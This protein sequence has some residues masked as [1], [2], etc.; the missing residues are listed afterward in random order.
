MAGLLELKEVGFTYL[1]GTPVA[2]EVLQGVNLALAEGEILCLLGRTGSGKTTLLQIMAGFLSPTRGFVLLNGED[3]NEE[4]RRRRGTGEVAMLMQASHRQLFAETVGKDVAFGPRRLGLRGKEL[5]ERVGLSL[6]AAG[7]DPGAY[8]HRSPFSLSD[9]EKRRAALAGILA[10]QPRFLLLDEPTAGLDPVAKKMLHETFLR[11]K[12]QGRGILLV[13]HDWEEVHSLADRVA[14]LHE[15][16]I[17]ARGG[18]EILVRAE[19]IAGA[20]LLPP[21][22]LRVTRGLQQK[23]GIKLFRHAYSPAGLAQAVAEVLGRED[24]CEA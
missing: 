14:L 2:K 16:R 11:L 18:K 15:G 10:L 1:P 20:G 3:M 4:R 22:L 8:K 21:P 6:R 12:E 13:T 19:E 24:G 9:G 17:A 5:E 23:L 7:L